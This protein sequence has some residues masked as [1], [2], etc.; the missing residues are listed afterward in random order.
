MIYASSGSFYRDVTVAPPSI[1][2]ISFETVALNWDPAAC[3]PGDTTRTDR[4]ARGRNPAVTGVGGLLRLCFLT[5]E[6]SGPREFVFVL[7]LCCFNKK[8]RNLHLYN[9]GRDLVVNS[10]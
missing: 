4:D 7:F 6:F 3:N 1:D 5:T 10:G 2:F 9:R 8:Y